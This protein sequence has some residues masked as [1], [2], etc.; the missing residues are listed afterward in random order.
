MN[1]IYIL[2]GANLGNPRAQ[3]QKAKELLNSRLGTIVNA[4]S[5]YKSEAWGVEDQ[6]VFLNQVLLIQSYHNPMDTLH[7]CQ[8]IENELGRKRK[9]KWGAR[10]ID[11]DILYFNNEIID[12]KELTIPHPY[13]QERRFTL[14][15]LC[16]I[17]DSY[18]HPKLNLSNKELLLNCSDILEVVK[19]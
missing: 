19:T 5:L 7:I 16:E 4:S 6:P 13:I 9:E 3:L 12:N 15:P 18:K 2:L 10:L 1:N 17:A 14:Q 8:T 11:I